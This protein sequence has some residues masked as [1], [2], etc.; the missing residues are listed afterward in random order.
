M[1]KAQSY[2]SPILIWNAEL[3]QL[4]ENAIKEHSREFLYKLRD[5]A[6]LPSKELVD[7]NNLPIYQ[8]KFKNIVKYP[9]IESEVRCGRY[10]LRVWVS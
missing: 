9:Q 8:K 7:P 1:Y 2:E 3:R 6:Q 5:F 10:Y 4:L